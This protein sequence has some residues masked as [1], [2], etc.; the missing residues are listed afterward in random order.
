[1]PWPTGVA[2]AGRA[3]LGRLTVGT[4]AAGGSWPRHSRERV[5]SGD[6]RAGRECRE[7]PFGSP[8]RRV[9][10]MESGFSRTLRG[11]AAAAFI[12]SLSACAVMRAP[13][14]LPVGTPIT[15]ARQ[16]YGGASGE[17]PLPGGGTRLEF[18]Q[19]SFGRQTF[20]LD[21]DASGRLVSTQQVLTPSTFA[22]ITPGMAQDE[23]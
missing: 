10:I 21:F 1:M 16:A 2:T 11:A 19:G 4:G 6:K 5:A 14:A 22:T 18:R 7:A 23:V 20:M 3:T 17:Y 9:T 12:A 13:A 8:H 15:E